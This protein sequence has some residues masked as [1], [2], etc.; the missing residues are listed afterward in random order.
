MDKPT[1]ANRLKKSR[2]ALGLTLKEFGQKI[3]VT[4][5]SVQR[6]ESSNAE[7]SELIARAIEQAFTIRHEWLLDG[8]GPQFLKLFTPRTEPSIGGTLEFPLIPGSPTC[9]EGGEIEDPGGDS[10]RYSLGQEIVDSVIRDC[11]AG[12]PETLFFTRCKGESMRPAIHDGDVALVNTAE[13]LRLQPVRDGIYLVRQDPGSND[14]MVK[15]VRLTSE[16]VVFHS[17]APGFRPISLPIDG[18]RLQDLVLGRVCWIARNVLA[19][20]APGRW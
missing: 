13:Q 20:E 12:R 17:D 14:A 4:A 15:R 16:D 7:V 6:W 1:A 8:T 10:P 9:G 5:T 11:G 18:I 2:R 19:D 3:G